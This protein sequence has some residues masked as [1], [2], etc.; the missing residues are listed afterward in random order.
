MIP[1]NRIHIVIYREIFS[2]LT[3]AYALERTPLLTEYVKLI[4]SGCV[5]AID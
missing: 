1:I 5:V 4:L 2:A 3:I